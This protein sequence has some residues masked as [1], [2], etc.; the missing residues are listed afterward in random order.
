MDGELPRAIVAD[1]GKIRQVVL[2]LVGNAVKFTPQG[3]SG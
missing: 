1:A 2:N 3:N